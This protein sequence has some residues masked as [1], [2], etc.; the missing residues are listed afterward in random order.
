MTATRLGVAQ[1]VGESY[2]A[3]ALRMFI[4]APVGI[5][6]GRVLQECLLVR[7]ELCVALESGRAGGQEVDSDQGLGVADSQTS[8]D[9]CPQIAAV[10][11]VAPVPS[12]SVVNVCHSSG[13]DHGSVSP[14]R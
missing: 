4:G 1:P 13:V 9:P 5:P 10:G 12:T 6:P 8:R 3:G 7:G 11:A 14:G 2:R